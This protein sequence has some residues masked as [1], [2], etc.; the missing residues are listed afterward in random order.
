MSLL[1][2]ERRTQGTT[3]SPQPWESNGAVDITGCTRKIIANRWTELILP[4]LLSTP[5]IPSTR[6]I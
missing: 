6:Q 3:A 1:C 4:P 2:S 5:W